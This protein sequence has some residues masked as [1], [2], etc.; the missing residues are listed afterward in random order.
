MR[1]PDPQQRPAFFTNL[2][3]IVLAAL[4]IVVSDPQ[5]GELIF[6]GYF[7]QDADEVIRSWYGRCSLENP[8]I[9]PY[10]HLSMP[11]W[12]LVLAVGEW[13]SQACGLPL[14]MLGRLT[15]VA[16]AWWCLRGVSDWVRA[17]GG[18][19]NHALIAVVLI[20]ASP[21]F[22]MLSLTVY[23]SIAF[24]T[25]AVQSFRFWAQD[26][27]RAALFAIGLTPLIRWEGVLLLALMAL[28]VLVKGLWKQGLW[29]LAPY[30]TYLIIN[31]LQFGNPWKPLA[32]RTTR[33][34]GAWLVFNPHLN[35]DNL[36]PAVVNLC[37]LYSPLLFAGA[38][39]VALYLAVR[40]KWDLGPLP[41]AAAGLTVALLSI[42]HE[43][44]VWVLRIFV[45][46]YSLAVMAVIGLAVHLS[47]K[48]RNLILALIAVAA[49]F[50]IG[51]TWH[52]VYNQTVP[53]PGN[54]RHEIGYHM[55]VRYSDATPVLSWLHAQKADWVIVNHLNANLFR[56]DPQ[57]SLYDLPL[58]IGSPG[59]SLSAKFEPSFGLPKGNGLVVFHAGAAGIE[60]CS[61]VK[62]FRESHLQ[63]YR[64]SDSG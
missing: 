41:W 9:I 28:F 1:L 34:M 10:S 35:L 31:A 3:G 59:M 45:T 57:C 36:W 15:T 13:I 47:N 6:R 12:T 32:F 5:I 29:L 43:W 11:G 22:F 61:L 20:A 19:H 42:Q 2:Y 62:V 16:A 21:A 37:S 54:L 50:S 24:L 44:T 39:A 64:C 63:I 56:A 26:R 40:R 7:V 46:P 14:T 58:R 38:I 4:A 30:L 25:L 27:P 23:P 49:L 18:N 48:T 55:F 53:K 52:K 8:L 60:K 17:I 51:S 33:H